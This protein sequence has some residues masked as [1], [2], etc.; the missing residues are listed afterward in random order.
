[1][2]NALTIDV[3]DYFHVS[4]F[5]SVCDPCTWPGRECRVEGN[6]FR[7]LD[8]LTERGVRATFFVLGWVAER[9]PGL[10]RRIAEE[11]HEVASH[12]Y[13]HRRVYTQTREEFRE[14]VRR[15][16]GLLEDL[17]GERV[18]GYRA[19]SYSISPTCLWAF[20]ELF[21][22]GFTYDSSV[23]PVRHDLYGIADWP[24]FAFR[25]ERLE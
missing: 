5:E 10:V 16:K 7:V 20:D 14:D 2:V 11:G 15:S 17:T 18:L 1:M 23:F 24:R 6:T 13:G 22:A 9:Y 12:G 25:L 3:E 4:A 21:E 8:L 19:P